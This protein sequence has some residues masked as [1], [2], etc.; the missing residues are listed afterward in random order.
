MRHRVTLIRLPYKVQ[1]K[2]KIGK[3]LRTKN[4]DDTF[5]TSNYFLCRFLNPG[6]FY[7]LQTKTFHPPLTFSSNG[8]VMFII[9]R[10]HDFIRTAH[11]DFEWA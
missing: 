4:P 7:C 6:F 2:K 5:I 8:A 11:P 1:M 3:K 10:I 9:I